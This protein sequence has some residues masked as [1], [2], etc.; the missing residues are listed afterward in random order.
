M[1]GQGTV[2]R[3]D[4]FETM[5]DDQVVRGRMDADFQVSDDHYEVIDW[6]TGR[7]LGPAHRLPA[8]LVPPGRSAS[9]A[10]QRGLPLR[11]AQQN[12]PAG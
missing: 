9:G 3:R 11:S 7:R 5:I 12:R 10:G 6:K 1:G 4:P 8:G 2:R